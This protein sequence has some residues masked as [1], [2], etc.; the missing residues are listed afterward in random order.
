[1]SFIGPTVLEGWTD[2]SALDELHRITGFS[3]IYSVD[4]VAGALGESLFGAA[5]NLAI[6]STC[7][8]ASVSADA[9]RES[10]GVQGRERQR[11]GN[12]SRADRAGRQGV[13]LRQSRMPRTL[14]V[15]ALARGGARAGR[16][17]GWRAGS[18]WWR[19]SPHGNRVDAVVS[20]SGRPPA[21][22]GVHDREPARSR[23]DRDRRL[24]AQGPGRA[25]R[26][27]RRAVARIGARRRGNRARIGSCF[28]N[29][30]RTAR[31]SARPCCRST[32]CCRRASKC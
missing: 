21:Q 7:T 8:S 4:S 12:R 16:H 18:C 1:M 3:V 2:L 32:K 19:C 9:G 30:T 10:L 11:D 28:R 23:D 13:L 15:A 25:H 20:G 5:K 29:T 26:C 22:C 6:F 31:S 27:A 14:P 24:G 17:E